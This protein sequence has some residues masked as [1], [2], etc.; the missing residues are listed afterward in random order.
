[1]QSKLRDIVKHHNPPQV[2]QC[3]E[4]LQ[5][6]HGAVD[7]VMGGL[8]KHRVA[9]LNWSGRSA[10]LLEIGGSGSWRA[11]GLMW[12]CEEP[13]RRIRAAKFSRPNPVA[14]PAQKTQSIFNQPGSQQLRLGHR[15]S[16]E[17]QR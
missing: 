6:Q 1:M 16:A 13:I 4:E 17:Q 12:G 11:W 10:G 7:V 5:A 15:T 9:T 14:R 8:P 3:P 2:R